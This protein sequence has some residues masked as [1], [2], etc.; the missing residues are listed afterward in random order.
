MVVYKDFKKDP[1]LIAANLFRVICCMTLGL[2]NSTDIESVLG[3]TDKEA[4]CGWKQGQGQKG[5][6]NSSESDL[7]AALVEDS[8]VFR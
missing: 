4:D 2:F 6:G 3:T 7:I 1:A 8:E 5:T